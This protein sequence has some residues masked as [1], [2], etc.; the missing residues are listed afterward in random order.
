MLFPPV[1]TEGQLARI[2]VQRML[3]Q[4]PQQDGSHVDEYDHRR[5]D[6]GIRGLGVT[7]SRIRKSGGK[8]TPRLRRCARHVIVKPEQEQTAADGDP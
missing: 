6:V 1:A 5:G 7:Q 2:A 8:P 4:R 3:E